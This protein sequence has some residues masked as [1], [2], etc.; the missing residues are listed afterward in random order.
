MFSQTVR[1]I[2]VDLNLSKTE[3]S[4]ESRSCQSDLTGVLKWA[5]HTVQTLKKCFEESGH[6]IF[7][8]A[9]FNKKLIRNLVN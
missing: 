1:L 4:H 5:A 6:K 8:L 9:T 3:T 2:S 7:I